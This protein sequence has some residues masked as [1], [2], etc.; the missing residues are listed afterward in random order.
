MDKNIPAH[1]VAAE[2]KCFISKLLPN[3]GTSLLGDRL[4]PCP[5]LRCSLFDPLAKEQENLY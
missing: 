2:R 4:I 1:S 3:A 5:F